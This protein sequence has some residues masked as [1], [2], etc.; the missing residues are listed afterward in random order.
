MSLIKKIIS[1][2]FCVILVA[3]IIVGFIS[4]GK[5]SRLEIRIGSRILNHLDLIN[6]SI[7]EQKID[8]NEII[9]AYDYVCSELD[10]LLLDYK[11][12][13]GKSLD[14]IRSLNYA[15]QDYA[16]LVR[17]KKSS[18]DK[19]EYFKKNLFGY[20]SALYSSGL[21]E[22]SNSS[23][24]KNLLYFE[25]KLSRKM[26]DH[27]LSPDFETLAYELITEK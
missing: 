1:C 19:L 26:D 6:S 5:L 7:S 3:L 13:T 11:V 2:L 20:T 25:D 16:Y 17:E 24:K 15:Y 14:S 12:V 23:I 8:E 27:S 4:L 22:N 9:S 21:E 10:A 18:P